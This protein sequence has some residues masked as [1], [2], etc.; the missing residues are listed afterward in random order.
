[1]TS[2]VAT[3]GRDFARHYDVIV[4]HKDYAAE[5]D[6]LDRLIRGAVPSGRPRVLDVGCGTGTHA[7]L[8]AAR[9]HEVTG[10]D[11]SPEM[12]DIARAKGGAPTFACLPLDRMEPGAFDFGY[13]VFNV[14]NCLA[15]LDELIS[16]FAD[17]AARLIRGA[18]L[19]VE[20]WNPIA[21]IA[22]PPETVERVFV[23]GGRR[24]VRTVTPRCDFLRQRLDLTYRIVAHAADG[25][26]RAPELEVVHGLVLFTPL[27]IE[28]ALTRAGFTGVR[29]LTALPDLREAT[30]SDRMLAFVAT[31]A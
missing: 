23:D 4:G 25:A 8:L 3:Y 14:V 30:A 1:V 10:T 15:G 20:S 2:S 28:H 7:L 5:V 6:A 27:E 29:V 26:D 11:L 17:V 22:E 12:I 31:L 21:V 9:G 13:S 24:I 19:L 18:T 16:F